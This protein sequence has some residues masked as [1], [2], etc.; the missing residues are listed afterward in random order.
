MSEIPP[1]ARIVFAIYLILVIFHICAFLSIDPTNGVLPPLKIAVLFLGA[2]TPFWITLIYQLSK[3]FD[4][5][6]TN[7]NQFFFELKNYL[8]T[9]I[10]SLFV[11]NFLYGFASFFFVFI[12][13]SQKPESELDSLRSITAHLSM[14]YV[15]AFAVITTLHNYR[16]NKS[17]SNKELH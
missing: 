14:F 1:S 11:I 5:K 6:T 4:F 13:A 17:T 2:L 15:F 10:K 12:S 16:H 9:W 3:T 8:P 7:G